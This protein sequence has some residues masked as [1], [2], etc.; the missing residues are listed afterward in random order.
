MYGSEC[1][2]FNPLCLY[3]RLTLFAPFIY[4]TDIFGFILSEMHQSARK[5]N[6]DHS[7]SLNEHLLVK[8]FDH[9]NETKEIFGKM[10]S[11]LF[12]GAKEI[13]S[14]DLWV[15][16]DSCLISSHIVT[17]QIWKCANMSVQPHLNYLGQT[18]V[19]L[20]VSYTVI[21]KSL[22]QCLCAAVATLFCDYVTRTPINDQ[23]WPVWLR[24][25]V[26]KTSACAMLTW[27]WWH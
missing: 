27:L 9:L 13:G 1:F 16:N 20:L 7:L 11:Q 8:L 4:E 10:S 26:R 15:V 17:V 2:H 18:W 22:H 24:Q 23:L 14:E 19:I 3:D 12:C 6:K 25:I 5:F 21:N